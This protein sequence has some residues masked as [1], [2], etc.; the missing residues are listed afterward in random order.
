MILSPILTSTPPRTSSSVL[1]VSTTSLSNS[2]LNCRPS[3]SP[4]RLI[5][6]KGRRN[7]SARS[8]L[9]LVQQPLIFTE[10]VVQHRQAAFR[11]EQTQ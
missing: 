8:A 1:A 7:L 11:S 5:Q 2:V 10:Y 6:I 4:L 9:A 3:F